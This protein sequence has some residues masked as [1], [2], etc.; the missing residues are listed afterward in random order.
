MIALKKSHEIAA[1]NVRPR[2]AFLTGQSDRDRYALSPAQR[3][4]LDA[5]AVHADGVHLD[6]HNFPWPDDTP[7]WRPVPLLRASFANGLQYLGARRGVLHGLSSAQGDMARGQLLA[8]PR[9]LL[10]IGSCGLS[11][12]DAL[13]APFDTTQRS[14]LRVVAY[15]AVASRWPHAIE[16]LQLRGDRDRIAAWLGPGDG[17]APHTLACG[18]M[19][20]LDHDAVISAARG[21][22]AWLRG[23]T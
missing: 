22:L 3:A 19:D 20:Y 9:T 1:V 16:G 15:G 2:I 18:H 5:I 7:P 12:L 17:P 21:Q 8:A 6:P 14:R 4:T 11:L 13:I 23:E 10:L